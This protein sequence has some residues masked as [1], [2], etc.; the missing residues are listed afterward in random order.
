MTVSTAAKLSRWLVSIRLVLND[1]HLC[2]L[3]PSKK[4]H[5]VWD[6]SLQ[7]RLSQNIDG[8]D[9]KQHGVIR[10][11]LIAA[12]VPPYLRHFLC[13]LSAFKHFLLKKFSVAQNLCCINKKNYFTQ[14]VTA[15]TIMLDTKEKCMPILQQKYIY[16]E[17]VLN[18]PCFYD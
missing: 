15:K 10:F 5:F 9:G 6:A 18:S 16:S 7:L 17:S 14:T 1:C 4:P 3:W 11:F 12:H 8:E 13:K 2:Y